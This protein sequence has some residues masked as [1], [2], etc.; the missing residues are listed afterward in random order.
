[1]Q[2]GSRV[3]YFITPPAATTWKLEPAA[4]AEQLR[5]AWPAVHVQVV[6][7]PERRH[8]IEWDMAMD[9]GPLQGSID[10][11]GQAIHLDSDIRNCAQ[12]AV[13][14][15]SI[16]PHE[17]ALIFFDEGYAVDI[18]LDAATTEATIVSAFVRT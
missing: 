10:R 1:M 2:R 14:F 4:L 3:S 8:A 12:F 17:Q 18:P 9:R 6:E 16:I 5:R 11:E 13:W 15:R 7:N